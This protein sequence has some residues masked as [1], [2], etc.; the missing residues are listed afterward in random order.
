MSVI[1]ENTI[2]NTDIFAITLI[3]YSCISVKYGKYKAGIANCSCV[4]L[5][6]NGVRGV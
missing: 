1:S 5:S 4:C 6:M 3:L 2:S